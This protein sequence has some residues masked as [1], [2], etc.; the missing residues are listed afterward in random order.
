MAHPKLA[1]DAKSKPVE[2]HCPVV[3]KLRPLR[4]SLRGKSQELLSSWHCKRPSTSDNA[5]W[6]GKN[7]IAA[8]PC[9]ND[10]AHHKRE[11]VPRRGLATV[12]R[13]CV[14]G[15]WMSS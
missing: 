5:D 3:I 14:S 11:A 2:I 6:A 1:R 13:R 4:P 10:T 15:W 9:G 8:P 7:R 12:G